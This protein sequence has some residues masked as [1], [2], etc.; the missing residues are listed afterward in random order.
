MM[1]FEKMSSEIYDFYDSG[2]EIGRL[3]RCL[4]K[5]EFARTKEILSR[6]IH[7]KCRIYDVGGGIGMYAVWLAGQGHQVDLLELSGIQVAYARE[8]FI[9]KAVFMAEEADARALPRAD[10]SADVVLLMGPLYH[11]QKRSD[12]ALALSEALRVLKPGGLLIA[13]GISKWSNMT[14]AVSS[15]T[16]TN[17]YL[18]D[19]VF[20]NMI[21]EEMETG[22]H[23]RP[24]EYR[25]FITEAYFHTAEELETEIVNEG[26]SVLG[27]HAVE[28]CIWLTPNLEENWEKPMRRKRLLQLARLTESEREM[29]GISPHF[30][31]AGK[32][33]KE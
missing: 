10:C 33:N 4:G 14:Y 19:D 7:E 16:D 5:I 23:N 15:F 2:V 18:D 1:N 11:L 24:E 12:R 17:M 20:F 21:K 26:F 3:E 27:L 8:H 13:A 9:D 32:K 29:I 25:S 28:G 31:I 6:Y 30:L 22:K